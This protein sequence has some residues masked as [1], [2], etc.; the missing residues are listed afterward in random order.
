MEAVGTKAG[1]KSLQAI[2]HSVDEFR[3]LNLGYTPQSRKD[4]RLKD[5]LKWHGKEPLKHN[6]T[7]VGHLH[8]QYSRPLSSPNFLRE[9]VGHNPRHASFPFESKRDEQEIVRAPTYRVVRY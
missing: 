1:Y 7:Q 6:A 9:F 5:G 8:Y 2:K 3:R 4:I